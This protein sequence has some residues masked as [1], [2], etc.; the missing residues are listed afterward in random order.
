MS[1]RCFIKVTNRIFCSSCRDL[2]LRWASIPHK[3]SLKVFIKINSIRIHYSIFREWTFLHL[4]K[5]SIRDNCSPHYII[6]FRRVCYGGQDIEL[7]FKSYIGCLCMWWDEC[8]NCL[9]L[10]LS[11][12]ICLVALSLWLFVILTFWFVLF[13]VYPSSLLCVGTF[14]IFN[15]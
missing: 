3:C 15:V 14:S 1:S 13:Y 8:Y 12:F 9:L 7:W 11:M 2:Y 4:R 10:G 6:M 5:T